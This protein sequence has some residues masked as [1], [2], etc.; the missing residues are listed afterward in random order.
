LLGLFFIIY[1]EK[2][3]LLQ[4]HSLVL[5]VLFGVGAALTFA[6]YT[7]YSTRIIAENGS[8]PTLSFSFL[9]GA[10]GLFIYSALAGKALLFTP[11]VS[12][13]S[14]LLYLSLFVTG[15]AYIMY[16]GAIRQIGAAR[17]SL[18]FFLKP[19]LACVLAW[20]LCHETLNSMQILG[21]LLIMLSL[22]RE[23][24]AGLF[25]VC[26]LRSKAA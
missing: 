20:L 22:S 5:G 9:L 8:L 13:L 6:L 24:L 14:F 16:F 1:G 7:V 21:V 26:F 15:L 2:T 3:A 18:Y 11:S 10:I 12:N 19:A 17:A 4:S 25:R 23:V